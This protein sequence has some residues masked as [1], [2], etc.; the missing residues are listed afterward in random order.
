[1][2]HK[3]RFPDQNKRGRLFEAAVDRLVTWWCETFFSVTPTGH[4]RSRTFE[5]VEVEIALAS[6]SDG[7]ESDD[8]G[9][10]RIRSVE[11]LMKHV[12]MQRGCRDT[13][14]QLFTALCRALDIP[15]RLVVSL[16]SVPW[17]SKVGKAAPKSDNSKGKGK[18]PQRFTDDHE[19]LEH[20]DQIEVDTAVS[21][22]KHKGTSRLDHVT[23]FF[24]KRTCRQYVLMV[25]S[26]GKGKEVTNP[27]IKLRKQ[28][29]QSTSRNGSPAIGARPLSMWNVLP[30][31][32]LSKRLCQLFSE[33]PD[34]TTTPPVFW[35]E[36]FSRADSR[37]LP[38]DPIRGIVNK[39]HLFDPSHAQNT[40]AGKTPI[41]QDNRMLYV[42]GLE[43]DGFG[44]DITPRY[45]R[46]YTAKVSKVQAVGAGAV[47]GRKEWWATVVQSITRPYRLVCTIRAPWMG[48][49]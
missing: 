29:S 22:S 6:E 24:L 41:R 8:S 31:R 26:T 23:E 13:S 7:S 36:V 35:T 40:G 42:I 16:Q 38:V 15:A 19:G 37:W 44:R 21:P 47:A 20:G 10:E 4:I 1:M 5:E 30:L 9:Y 43:E 18:A 39:R 45:A 49:K 17:K 25:S 12:L 28:K 14:A 32:V 33:S 48:R 3:S 27:I 11:S 46:E 2:I 34:P